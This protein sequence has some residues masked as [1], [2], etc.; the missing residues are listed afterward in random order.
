MPKHHLEPM[1]K[2]DD[3]GWYIEDRY[4]GDNNGICD[5]GVM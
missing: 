2:I 4:F 1:A 5:G 3:A